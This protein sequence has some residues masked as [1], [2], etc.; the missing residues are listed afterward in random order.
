MV[1]ESSL[2]SRT[3][4]FDLVW[5]GTCD[6]TNVGWLLYHWAKQPLYYIV[7]K[8]RLGDGALQHLQRRQNGLVG[9]VVKSDLFDH[10]IQK[11]V[12]WKTYCMVTIPFCIE[13]SFISRE[14]EIFKFIPSFNI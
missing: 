2:S 12:V 7:R 5:I 11:L 13:S 1:I 3:N 6:P 14:Q 8:K 4:L 9:V 10:R